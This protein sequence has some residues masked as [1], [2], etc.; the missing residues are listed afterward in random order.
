M[1]VD[2]I[3]C[4]SWKWLNKQVWNHNFLPSILLAQAWYQWVLWHFGK[5]AMFSTTHIWQ[6]PLL[7]HIIFL[8]VIRRVHKAKDYHSPSSSNQPCVQNAR[9]K[10][11]QM[12]I[13][14][15]RWST[16][17]TGSSKST[18]T[19]FFWAPSLLST[20]PK[21]L[22]SQA[23]IYFPSFFLFSLLIYLIISL[24]N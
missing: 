2:W 3:K 18:W 19:I 14:Q 10:G 17:S 6:V 1:G 13:H 24:T 12:R 7:F 9:S 4:S 22:I 8:S 21:M 5:L 15:R 23:H 16:R 11:Y 20:P